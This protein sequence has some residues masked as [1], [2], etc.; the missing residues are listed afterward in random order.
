MELVFLVFLIVIGFVLL[1][2]GAKLLCEG[3][4]CL[5]SKLCVS[6]L[7][8]GMTVI[9]LTTAA[10]ECVSVCFAMFRGYNEMAIAN[11]FGG[12]FTNMALGFGL[13]AILFPISIDKRIGK[14]ELPILF[15]GSLMFLMTG[16]ICPLMFR[17]VGVIFLI[18]FLVYF[19][20]LLRFK[21]NHH[22]ENEVNSSNLT[23]FRCIIR[24]IIGVCA[25]IGGAHFVID[26]CARIAESLNLSHSFIGFTIVALG[27][28]LPEIFIAIYSVL[29]GNS[30]ICTGN[31]IGSSFV[32]LFFIGGLAASVGG[33]SCDGNLLRAAIPAYLIVLL[34]VLCVFLFKKHMPRYVGFLLI[35][36]YFCALYYLK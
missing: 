10:P 9:S 32:N 11:V 23:V 18:T 36:V 30:S 6:P 21:V 35:S 2:L 4:A 1:S 3:G 16:L 17:V 12:N 34:I 25:L 29:S 13:P 26:P 24:I 22:C 27:T 20:V 15:V 7:F 5:S 28:S 14:I 31:I 33:I 8:I 19:Y